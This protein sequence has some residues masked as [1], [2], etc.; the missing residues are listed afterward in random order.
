VC[1]PSLSNIED[2]S[3]ITLYVCEGA[4]VVRARA[5]ARLCTQRSQHSIANAVS[6]LTL[7]KRLLTPS[8]LPQSYHHIIIYK[9]AASTLKPFIVKIRHVFNRLY[10]AALSGH[11]NEVAHLTLSLSANLRFVIIVVV[12]VVFC[13]VIIV[14]VVVFR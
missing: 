12:V 14:I 8:Y 5:V 11:R 7:A 9:N 3:C 4:R 1:D 2:R 13:I 6:V 10:A